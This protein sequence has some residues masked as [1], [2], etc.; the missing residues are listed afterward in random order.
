MLI[1]WV[2]GAEG[3]SIQLHLG[4]PGWTAGMPVTALGGRDGRG[5]SWGQFL[6]RRGSGPGQGNLQ[7]VDGR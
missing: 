4:R 5:V 1:P 3:G 7:F 6:W 2:A